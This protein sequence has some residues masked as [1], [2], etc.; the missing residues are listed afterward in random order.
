M[1]GATRIGHQRTVFEH[2]IVNVRR[3]LALAAAAALLAALFFAISPVL[4]AQWVPWR[5]EVALPEPVLPARPASAPAAIPGWAWEM[6]AWHA[7]RPADRG[8]RPRGAP[9]RLPEWYWEWRAWRI[10]VSGPPS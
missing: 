5:T 6:H 4:P 9:Q 7:T 3:L 1:L 8:R 10:A 2:V